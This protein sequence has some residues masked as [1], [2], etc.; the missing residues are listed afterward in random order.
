MKKTIV[1]FLLV[2]TLA[3]AVLPVSAIIGGEEDF[4]HGNVGAIMMEWPQ[5]GNIVGRL[6]SGTLIHERALLTAAHCYK[7][8]VD[9]AYKDRFF[10]VRDDPLELVDLIMQPLPVKEQLATHA[11]ERVN[12]LRA[13]DTGI[14]LPSPAEIPDEEQEELKALGYL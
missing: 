9:E 13:D 12:R 4:E 5:F 10:D 8:I 11:R 14:P 2:L 3:V 7:Y 6:C 1:L